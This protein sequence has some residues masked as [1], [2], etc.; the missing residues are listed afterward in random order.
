MSSKPTFIFEKNPI[1]LNSVRVLKNLRVKVTNRS[2]NYIRPGTTVISDEWR[3]YFDIGIS[4]YTHQTVNHSENFV[5]PATG[6][7][8]QSVEG[9]WSCTKRMMRKQGVMNTSSSLFPTYLLEYLWRRSKRSHF[10]S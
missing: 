5:D 1:L 7:H 4:G 10:F 2:S 6:A 8:T 3:A 9:H